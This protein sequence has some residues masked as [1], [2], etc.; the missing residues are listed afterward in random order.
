[1]SECNVFCSE[2]LLPVSKS[3]YIKIPKISLLS[4]N[5][6]QVLPSIPRRLQ[7]WSPDNPP[8]NWLSYTQWGRARLTESDLASKQEQ[9]GLDLFSLPDLSRIQSLNTKSYIQ[10]MGPNY[11]EIYF[12]F[13]CNAFLINCMQMVKCLCLRTL[14]V[15][16]NKDSLLPGDHGP[17]LHSYYCPQLFFQL[18]VIR[19]I[20][21]IQVIFS[22]LPSIFHHYSGPFIHSIYS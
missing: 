7:P 17:A 6:C 9:I 11:H 21:V 12:K 5:S 19:V 22:D 2:M 4:P 18:C 10:H 3:P 1:M 15:T 13:L 20:R 16:W 8:H 14:W